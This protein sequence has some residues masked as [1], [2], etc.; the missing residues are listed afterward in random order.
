MNNEN[1]LNS[2]Y[3]YIKSPDLAFNSQKCENEFSDSCNK[4]CEYC[5]NTA[6]YD[7]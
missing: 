6:A 5:E 7:Y 4:I 1:N 2:A 3:F